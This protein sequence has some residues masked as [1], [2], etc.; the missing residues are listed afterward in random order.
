MMPHA[1]DDHCICMGTF[2][3]G[4][5]D[6]ACAAWMAQMMCEYY[7]YTGDG[8]FLRDFAFEFMTGVMNVYLAMLEERGGRLSL[9]VSVSPEYRG[10]EINAWGADPSFQL[11]AIHRLAKDLI[12]VAGI[13]GK[14]VDPAW[15]NVRRNLPEA[16]LIEVD[17]K[18]QI[19]LWEGVPLEESHRHHSHL[20]GICPFATLRPDDPKWKDVLDQSALHWIR[21]G[22]GRWAGWSMPWAAMLH[23]RLG[24]AQMAEV[25]IE[26]W[27]RCFVNPGGGTL[28]NPQFGGFCS[29]FGSNEIMQMDAGLGIVAAIQDLFVYALDNE[30]YLMSGCMAEPRREI[31]V[32]NLYC[33]GGFVAELHRSPE[34]GTEIRLRATRANR[35]AAHLPVLPHGW[36]VDGVPFDGN[37]L[38]REMKAGEVLVLK[39]R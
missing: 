27:H 26:I 17:G 6:H 5:I 21:M 12:R 13:L 16:T 31:A 20:A 15:E 11:A 29:L 8:E 30:L 19:A 23:N 14:P 33:P 7:D 25:V 39:S 37:F 38:S 22:M 3:S 36:T 24:N 9:P 28:H 10:A 34:D 35:L 32:N 4:T 2:W 1:V 18:Q